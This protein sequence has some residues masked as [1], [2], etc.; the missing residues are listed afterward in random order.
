VAVWDSLI[1]VGDGENG[2]RLDLLNGDG[3]WVGQMCVPYHP[4]DQ[5]RSESPRREIPP[6][7]RVYVT[8]SDILWVL[9]PIMPGE[10]EW[11]ALGL[12]QNGDVVGRLRGSVGFAPAAIFDDTVYSL[13]VNS[14]GFAWLTADGIQR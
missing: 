4:V 12:R 9:F 10:T 2:F 14:I 5:R 6:F 8:P 11:T 13:H 3:V 1:V 7:V